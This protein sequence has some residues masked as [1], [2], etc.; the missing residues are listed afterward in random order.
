MPFH[1]N[2]RTTRSTAIAMLFVWL[3]VLGMGMA[4][5]CLAEENHARHGH[6]QHHHDPGAEPATTEAQPDSHV[7][8]TSP[9]KAACQN[10]CADAQSSVCK[11]QSHEPGLM[12]PGVAL[13]ALARWQ[14]SPVPY[15]P[16][17]WALPRDPAW[18][19][20]SVAIRFLRLTL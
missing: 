13:T 4:N 18:T 20:P 6:L 19:E 8:P 14:V 3:L 9:E 12:D 2:R 5:A 11:Q 7:S 15:S 16:S 10:F 17:L 1:F